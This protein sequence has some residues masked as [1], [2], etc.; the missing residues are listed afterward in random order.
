[1]VDAATL[2][3]IKRI[4]KDVRKWAERLQEQEQLWDN[5]LGCMC[6]IASYELF[7]RLRKARLDPTICFTN[8]DDGGH[9]FISCQGHIVD[10][11]ATQFTRKIPKVIVI[12]VKEIDYM[13]YEFWRPGTRAKSKKRFLDEIS[14]WPSYQIHPEL[15]PEIKTKP[16][17]H[18]I[19]RTL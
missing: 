3:K 5:N 4:A 2:S 6:A 13:T 17:R 9:A 1:M 11:T 16:E 19:R 14:G 8:G 12:P 10:V 15:R 7:K 18:S